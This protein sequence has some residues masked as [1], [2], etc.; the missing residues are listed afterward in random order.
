MNTTQP[1]RLH[2]AKFG[3]GVF[4][5]G[6]GQ[7]DKREVLVYFPGVGQKRLLLKFAGLSVIEKP[8]V[9]SG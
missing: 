7:G 4:M 9:A 6:F 2:H 8:G 5:Q 3:D 1:L